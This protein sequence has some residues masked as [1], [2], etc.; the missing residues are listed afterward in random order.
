MEKEWYVIDMQIVVGH[1]VVL[2]TK[3]YIPLKDPVDRILL[4]TFFKGKTNRGVQYKGKSWL[5]LCPNPQ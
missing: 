3:L 5:R 4:Y 1:Y 2:V